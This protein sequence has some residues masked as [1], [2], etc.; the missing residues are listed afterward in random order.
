MKV[1]IKL[2][3]K[4]AVSKGGALVAPAGAKFFLQRF[5]LLAFF[6][7]LSTSKKKAENNLDERYGYGRGCDLTLTFPDLGEGQG[8]SVTLPTPISFT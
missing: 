7:A 2:F 4:F 6:F 5:F 8:L 1:L 3:Q